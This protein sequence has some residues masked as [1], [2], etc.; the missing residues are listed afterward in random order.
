M[1][2]QTH[3]FR[4]PRE[5]RSCVQADGS[6]WF[7]AKD[8]CEFLDIQWKG[9]L[10]LESL[11]EDEQGVWSFRTPSSDKDGRG[12]GAQEGI[13][14]SESGL[15]RLTFR[16]N[17][18]A[19]RAFTRWVTH[20]VLP[21]IRRTGGYGLFNGNERSLQDLLQEIQSRLTHGDITDIAKSIGVCENTV[22]RYIGRTKHNITAKP[23]RETVRKMYEWTVKNS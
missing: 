11:D 20:E 16:S 1:N 13:I 22:R 19:A 4:Q 5:L 7:V 12:G 14:I 9:K 21:S 18:P 15:Y 3:I 17:K 2:L 6:I 8:V 10:S 23:K